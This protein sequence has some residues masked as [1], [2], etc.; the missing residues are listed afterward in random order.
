MI[1]RRNWLRVTG[2]ASLAGALGCGPRKS[3]RFQGYALISNHSGHSLAVIDLS[4]FQQ[5][6]EIP[7]D[8]APSWVLAAPIHNRAF[9]LSVDASRLRVLNLDTM[10]LEQSLALGGRPRAAQLSADQK[11]L[12]ILLESPNALLSVNVQSITVQTRVGLPGRGHAVDEHEGLLAIAFHDDRRVGC[13]QPGRS[14]LRISGRLDAAPALISIRQDGKVLLT[15]NPDDRGI[16][17]IDVATLNPLVNLPLSLAPTHF[18][19][20]RDGG[21][22]FVTGEGMDAVVIVSPYQTEVNETILAGNAPGAMATSAGAPNYLFVANPRSGD[23]TIIN[24]DNRKVLAQIQV[25]Q[26]PGAILVT[27]D[28]EYALVLNEQSADVAV[29]RLMNI[30]TATPENRRT[31]TAGLFTLI[32]VGS[33]PVGGVVIPRAS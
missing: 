24:I 13:Y 22:L 3:P 9:I 25:G 4:R 2:S 12:W 19:V 16:T 33:G 5:L 30:R 6:K 28:N 20:N 17:A 18:C 31:R 27:P 7:L 21:Q 15:G 23:V 26:R 8:A 14:G 10:L 1:S 32:P 11:T 29:I